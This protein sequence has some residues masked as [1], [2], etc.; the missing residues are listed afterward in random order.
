[1]SIKEQLDKFEVNEENI[2]V[3]YNYF[4]SITGNN[5]PLIHFGLPKGCVFLRQRINKENELFTQIA[6]LSYPP[7]DC[8]KEYG[9][10]NVPYKPMF[11]GSTFGFD[12]RNELPLPRMLV[13][14]ETST[15]AK[16]PEKSG[17][18]R[19]TCSKW[20]AQKD[21]NLIALPF[22]VEYVRPLNVIKQIQQEWEVQVKKYDGDKRALDLVKYMSDE[23]AK[24]YS[25]NLDTTVH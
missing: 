8:V 15:F 4:D 11:Y 21:L 25:N 3:L 18:E 24:N 12:F 5:I 1:M 10:A 9:R 7:A 16:D 14:L 19:S 2:G 23:I 6:E 13:L 17:I 20:M 22:S